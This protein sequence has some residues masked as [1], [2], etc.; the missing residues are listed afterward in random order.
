VDNGKSVLPT[1]AVDESTAVIDKLFKKLSHEL[2]QRG[3]PPAL[4]KVLKRAD[5]NGDGKACLGFFSLSLSIYI[6][7]PLSLYISISLSLSLIGVVDVLCRPGGPR[8]AANGTTRHGHPADSLR[9]PATARDAR[10]RPH[11][12]QLWCRR[13]GEGDHPATLLLHSRV[14]SL[15]VCGVGP[16]NC[17]LRGV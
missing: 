17:T 15:H 8:G 10:Q 16:R 6:Y 12:R 7:I 9:L 5:V 1:A 2:G 13:A 11:A 3:G 14:A 4:A